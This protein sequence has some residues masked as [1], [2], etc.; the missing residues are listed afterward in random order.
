MNRL[1]KKLQ[2]YQKNNKKALISFLTAGHPCKDATVDAMK[3]LVAGGSDVIELGMPFSDPEA[4]GPAIQLSSQTA[5]EQGL[6][7]KDYLEMVRAFRAFDDETPLVYMGYLNTV[8]Q[9][10]Y[11]QFAADIYEAGID[12][13]ILVNLPP[14]LSE[15]L[16]IE[17]DKYGISLILLLSL[18]TPEGRAKQ[19]VQASSGFVYFVSLKGVTGSGGLDVSLVSQHVTAAKSFSPLPVMIGFGIKDANTAK[20][21]AQ[22]SDGIIIGSALVRIMQENAN[23]IKNISGELTKFLL[24]VREA[25]DTIGE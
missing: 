23:D 20:A 24:P 18:T 13:L 14:E 12:A 8:F 25:L 15:P 16:T 17:L 4:E 5:L 7:F 3:A 22:I 2:S 19:I 9:I 21:L 11:A 1:E 10:S 6:L